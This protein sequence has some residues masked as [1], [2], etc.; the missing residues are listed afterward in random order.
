VF[1]IIYA[2]SVLD[3]QTI[4]IYNYVGDNMKDTRGFTLVELLAVITILVLLGLIALEAIDSINKRNREDAELIQR[5]N[6]LNAVISYVP[7]SS[8]K[9][10]NLVTTEEG[11]R[12]SNALYSIKKGNMSTSV[13]NLCSVSI[14]LDYLMAFGVLEYGIKNP[15]T[16]KEID[17][18]KA[19]VKIIYV[20]DVDN[21]DS[22]IDKER[23][24]KGRFDGQYFYEL[25]YE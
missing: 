15:L 25:Y 2:T 4:I 14:Y 18:E 22:I 11:C 3:F 17:I 20:T 13:N 19:Y 21:V 7:T 16:G 8:I 9:L 23:R 1:I 10:P 6:I 5:K 24:E 12:Y